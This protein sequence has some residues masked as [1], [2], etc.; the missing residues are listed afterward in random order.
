MFGRDVRGPLDV[1]K[2]EWIA[3]QQDSQSVVSHILLMRERLES[4][5]ELTR[6]NLREAQKQQKRWYDSKAR[7]RHLQAG[8][9]VLVLLPTSTSKLLA[10]WQGPFKVVKKVSEV[11]YEVETPGSRRKSKVFH[12][13]MLQKWNKP[14]EFSAYVVEMET[15]E[16]IPEWKDPDN[17]RDDPILG[18]Q[19][20]PLQR[21]KFL[22]MLREF[23]EV[24][25]KRCGQTSLVNHRIIVTNGRPVRQ[26]PYRLP[27]ACKDT[28]VKQLE[29]M[30]EEGVIEPS[31]SEWSFPMVLVKKKDETIR[32]CID[33]RKLNAVTEQDAY[34]MPRVDDILDDIGQAQYVTTLDLAKGYWQVPVAREDRSKTAFTTPIGL[35]QFKVMPFGL[36]GAPATFQKLMDEVDLV[37]LPRHI[38]MMSSF[39]VRAGKSTFEWSCQGFEKLILQ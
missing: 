10:R 39:S 18:V 33:Y 17:T 23:P 31:Q 16:E 37:S 35:F 29:E 7:E 19:L 34:P 21:A 28:V 36:C 38:W 6:E 13:N 1:L 12:I 5:Y 32:I 20:T 2:E 11:N 24:L 30:L 14:K 8:E 26:P 27:H 25:S 22:G 15:L 3:Q 9:E 4:M